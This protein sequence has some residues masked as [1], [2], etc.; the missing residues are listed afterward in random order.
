[1]G[2]TFQLTIPKRSEQPIRAIYIDDTFY[3]LIDQKILSIEPTGE[4]KFLTDRI[5]FR[6]SDFDYDA[7]TETFYVTSWST[8]LQDS[9]SQLALW[10]TSEKTWDMLVI[11]GGPYFRPSTIMINDDQII[12]GGSDLQMSKYYD[13][14]SAGYSDSSHVGNGII[15]FLD[16]Q[17]ITPTVDVDQN[18]FEVSIFP[19]PAVDHVTVRSPEKMSRIQVF[20]YAGRLVQD[21]QNLQL[22]AY[23]LSVADLTPGTYQL[24]IGTRDGRISSA[25]LL[26]Q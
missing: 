5:P 24:K 3:V 11:P 17:S 19:N 6:I 1:M 23:Q 7:I 4:I 15:R 20:D 2:T 21:L 12:V 10:S 8:N 22:E 16:L 9:L 13:D 18:D 14:Y 25:P 26:V